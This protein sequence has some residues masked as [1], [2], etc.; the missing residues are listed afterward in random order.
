[1][2]AQ[3]IPPTVTIVELAPQL[4]TRWLNLRRRQPSV[5]ASRDAWAVFNFRYLSES[6]ASRVT[7]REESGPDRGRSPHDYRVWVMITDTGEPVYTLDPKGHQIE[8]TRPADNVRSPW[9]GDTEMI[10][11][12]AASGAARHIE[13]VPLDNALWTVDT[14]VNVSDGGRRL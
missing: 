4:N 7:A 3:E 14:L 12:G 6:Y 8:F 11:A 9:H 2:K 5:I 1:M 13:K 10:R